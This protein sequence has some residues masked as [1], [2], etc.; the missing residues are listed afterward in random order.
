MEEAVEAGEGAKVIR[1]LKALLMALRGENAGREGGGRKA[2]G[3]GERQAHVN[4]QRKA[5]GQEEA[6]EEGGKQ[7]KRGSGGMGGMGG[8]GGRAKE[9]RPM[10]EEE[11][12]EEE[13]GMDEDRSDRS[14]D[15][16]VTAE[17]GAT[18]GETAT[19]VAIEGNHLCGEGRKEAGAAAA[20]AAAEA[21]A[22]TAA[23]GGADGA[24]EVVKNDS[25]SS[26]SNR[27]GVKGVRSKRARI[28]APPDKAAGVPTA[29]ATGSPTGSAAE[30]VGEPVDQ[31]DHL[32]AASP[33]ANSPPL[34][35]SSEGL[36]S[37]N[38]TLDIA[39]AGDRLA[40]AFTANL[41]KAS[42]AA[43]LVRPGKFRSPGFR[44]R[45]VGRKGGR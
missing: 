23:G 17:R 18:E 4:A 22:G 34:G 30:P 7:G 13:A 19:D 38:G 36:N 6:G 2:Q 44:A 40:T 10:V 33:A 29:I 11:Q 27:R 42:E 45:G 26:S 15:S 31:Q 28:A 37:G 14:A 9:G 41:V 8:M 12:D 16:D 1:G 3:G 35:R 20:A 21:A 24:A 32:P 25:S 39:V 5:Q 43:R